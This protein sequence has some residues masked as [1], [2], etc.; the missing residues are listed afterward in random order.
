M[1]PHAPVVTAAQFV[2]QLS[3]AALLGVDPRRFL[4]VVVPLCRPDVVHVGKLRLI[5]VARAVDVLR[6]MVAGDGA[7]GPTTD[8]DEP[9]QPETA[10]EVLAALGLERV[11]PER[12][13]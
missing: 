6:G 8:E 12:Q 11:A 4:D 13:P 3:C 1:R 7:E 5:E 10:E 2:S 9:G